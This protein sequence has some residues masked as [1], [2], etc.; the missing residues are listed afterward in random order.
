MSK[1]NILK[2]PII[3]NK[4]NNNDPLIIY[5]DQNKDLSELPN[6]NTKNVTVNKN[7]II[8]NN[9]NNDNIIEYFGHNN[10][11]IQ[12]NKKD[13]KFYINYGEHKDF[14]DPYEKNENINSSSNN[15][16]FNNNH[17][18][19]HK[20]KKI[21]YIN[22]FNNKNNKDDISI[23]EKPYCWNLNQNIYNNEE[24][25]NNFFGNMGN[26]LGIGSNN[27]FG[28]DFGNQ[29]SNFDFLSFKPNNIYNNYNINN[30][31]SNWFNQNHNGNLN[32]SNK[33]GKGQYNY[34]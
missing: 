27:N 22:K 28:G 11:S 34:Q 21:K 26:N 9:D 13:K 20:F 5:Q 32:G 12:Y 6:G 4:D 8:I 17:N 3:N 30:N 18:Q 24:S 23:E 7:P 2:N 14:P 16:L 1:E 29:N 19:N 33:K 10:E 25:N 31:T 15:L